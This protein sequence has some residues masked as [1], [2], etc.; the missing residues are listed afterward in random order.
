MRR[1]PDRETRKENRAI[2]VFVII[3][4]LLFIL[5]AYGWWTGAWDTQP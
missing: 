1:F 4:V 5:A 3:V 2:W